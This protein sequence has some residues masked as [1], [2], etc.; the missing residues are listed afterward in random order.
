MEIL[1]TQNPYTI[2]GSEG[3][4]AAALIGMRVTVVG[5]SDTGARVTETGIVQRFEVRDNEISIIIG[6]LAF[7]L[8]SVLRVE[9]ADARGPGDDD[10]WDGE[11]ESEAPPAS[12]P[13]APEPDITDA[14]DEFNQLIS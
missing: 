14:S 9:S 5:R 11:G 13:P 8:S 6:D 1:P 2:M 10:Y 7:P 3:A 4:Y 12:T